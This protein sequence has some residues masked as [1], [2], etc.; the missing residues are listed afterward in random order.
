MERIIIFGA[1]YHTKYTIDIIEQQ[2]LYQIVGIIDNNLEAGQ[3]YNGYKILGNDDSLEGIVNEL[4]VRK[5]IIAIGDN[6]IRSKVAERVIKLPIN[7]EFVSATHPSVI[8]GKNVEIGLGT[9]IMA[10]VIINNDS[11]IGKHCFL[12][13]KSSLD[14]DST[15]GNFVSLSPGVTT[16]GNVSIGT[17]TVIGIGANILHNIKIGDHTVIG[18]GSLVS[19]NFGNEIVAYGVPAKEIRKRKIGDK[20]L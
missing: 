15:I 3:N 6:F 16:G 1:S 7:F 10:G 19:K 20:Y 2:C 4:N 12:A 18:A 13:T 9:V 11:V 17:C 14:H 8:I 5:G